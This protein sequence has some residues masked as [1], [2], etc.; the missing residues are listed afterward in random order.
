VR[1]K[2]TVPVQW[3]QDKV[4]VACVPEVDA[5]YMLRV[6]PRGG[7]TLFA[8]ASAAAEALPP[9]RLAQLEALDCEHRRAAAP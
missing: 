7:E 4:D 1:G 9:G 5:M 8:S 3:H 6:P 2:S